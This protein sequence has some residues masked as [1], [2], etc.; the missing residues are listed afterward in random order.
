MT[1]PF[2]QAFH[3]LGPRKLPIRG[4][5]IHMAEG[6]GTVGFLS[7]KNRDGVSVHYV[8]DRAGGITQMLLE[9]HMHSSIR[10]HNKNGASAI[11]RT[12]DPD[13]IF[14]RTAALAVLGD[15]ADTVATLG[16]NHSTLSVE[17]E[18]FARDG[19][20]TAQQDALEVLVAD[21]RTRFPD[22]GLLGHRDFNIK[23]CPGKLIPWERLGGHATGGDMPG[24]ETSLPATPA[25]GTLKIPAGTKAIQ[26]SNHASFTVPVAVTRRAY[27]IRLAGPQTGQGFLVDLNGNV[28]H[29]IRKGS[30]GLV[31]R[32]AP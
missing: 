28:T 24:V 3:D 27:R 16:P 32:E 25:V 8:I 19:P 10:I 30:P 5:T 15:R 11:R 4:F 1:F 29:F 17:I 31:F 23:G 22:I 14:G 20:N 7:R 6:G 21:I 12:D 26:L 9:D 2:V 13:G 18:G